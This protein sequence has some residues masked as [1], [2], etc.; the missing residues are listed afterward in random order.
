M[1]TKV[2]EKNIKA[3]IKKDFQSMQKLT[4]AQVQELARIGRNIEQHYGWPQDI[5]WATEGGKMYIV[6]SRPITTLKKEVTDK[7]SQVGLPGGKKE[8]STV[9]SSA[10]VES[11]APVQAIAHPAAPTDL[12][13]ATSTVSKATVLLKGLPAS[14]GFSTNRV[15]VLLN[16]DDIFKM[17]SG[18]ILVTVM[19]TP[20]F[21]PAMR[22]ASAIITDAGGLTSHAAIVSRELGVPAVIGTGNAT[23]RLQDGMIVT[24]DAT[25]GIVYEGKV[26]ISELAKPGAAFGGTGESVLV[27]ATK[28]YVN[29]AE[30][31]VAEKVAKLAVDGVGLLRA[32][33]MVAN[34][35][36]HPRKMFED[37]KEQE[38]IDTLAEGLSRIA[39]AFFPR[40]VV[41]RATDFKT[42][43]YRNLKG[44][45]K[46][47]PQEEN[48]MIGY[49]GAMRYIREPELFA[50]ELK[51]IKK[52]RE[53]MGLKNLWLMIPFV[54]RTEQISAI[55]RL[56]EAEGLR[57]TKDFKLWIMVEVPSSV[58]MI[59][60]MCE[61]GIDGVSIG[62]N[63]L[64]QLILGVDRDNASIASEFDE[65]STAVMRAMQHVIKTCRKYGV[66]ASICGQAPSV[67]PELTE[68]LV[69]FGTTSVSV[70]PDAIDKTRRIVASAEQKVLLDKMRKIAEKLGLD[71]GEVKHT[72][73]SQ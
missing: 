45:D 14:P 3:T 62:S 72:L 33:F 10:S 54:R 50:M 12:P 68:K 29:V 39:G 26:D 22:K 58:F 55:K 4:D 59:E 5:E 18:E 11:A 56:M 65:R 53:D 70:N 2:G 15:R 28:V 61:E 48:P 51:A 30:P 60:E 73:P 44:G 8:E 1:L 64:T 47:E 32:E 34:M 27:T 9:A 21:V 69:E 46:Y 20:D 23:K 31:D 13:G 42:N 19:T 6:Q 40:P 35:G 16:L 43:E 57:R 25:K 49:R 67:Y 7:F 52:V 71:E 63:D 38:F 24:V 41:Y 36:V 66:T 17:K 37:G